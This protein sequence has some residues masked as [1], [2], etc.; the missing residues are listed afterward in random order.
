MFETPVNS[1]SAYN[2]SVASRSLS[3]CGC[4]RPKAVPKM[5]QAHDY[6]LEGFVRAF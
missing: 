3:G 5:G 6:G 1:A 4:G 2:W